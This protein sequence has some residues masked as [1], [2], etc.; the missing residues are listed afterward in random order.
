MPITTLSTLEN[1]ESI[2]RGAVLKKLGDYYGVQVAYF[3]STPSTELKSTDAA[4]AWLLHLRQTKVL[5]NGIAT[6][7]S[8]DFP[9]ELKKRIARTIEQKK[10]G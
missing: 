9:E 2:P 7:A 3:Y 5:E 4:K 1:Q 6:H 8:P 10:N